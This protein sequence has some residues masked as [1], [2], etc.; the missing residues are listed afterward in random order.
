MIKKKCIYREEHLD[1]DLC[2]STDGCEGQMF[3]TDEDPVFCMIDV[4][5]DYARKE[6]E[7]N[8]KNNS[9]L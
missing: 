8:D 5:E 7:R 9:N 1:G 4:I 3:G 6:C 2:L